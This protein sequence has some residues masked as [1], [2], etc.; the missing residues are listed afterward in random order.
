[1]RY[2]TPEPLRKEHVRDGFDCG[3]PALNEWLQK[4]ALVSQASDT[5]R[6]YVVTESDSTVVAGYYA[7]AAAHIEPRDAPSRVGKGQPR[8]RPIPV[9]LLARL[10][11]DLNHQGAGLGRSLLRDA[12]ARVAAAA[13]TIGLRA[14]VVHAK[15]DEARA[16]Y[17]AFGFEPSPTD[18]LHMGILMKAVR[19]TIDGLEE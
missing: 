10:A 1:V 16:W 9:V 13:D 5:A 11:V 14:I 17:A 15:D 6:V 4:Y 19:A 18:P 7:L 12:L 2:R 3:K 8:R